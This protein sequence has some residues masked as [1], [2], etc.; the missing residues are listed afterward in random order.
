MSVVVRPGLPSETPARPRSSD[1]W[2]LA[3]NL[4]ILG[5]ALWQGWSLVSL[6]FPFWLQSVAIGV[7]QARRMWL[8]QS[9][10]PADHTTQGASRAAGVC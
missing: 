6:L 2:L 3:S 8:L 4:L 10:P 5:L 9:L 1:G 7:L